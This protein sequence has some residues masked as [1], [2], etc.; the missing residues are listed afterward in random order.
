MSR[1]KARRSN[2]PIKTEP[3]SLDQVRGERR[4]VK[5]PFQIN[6]RVR[7]HISTMLADAYSIVA[8]ELRVMREA[9]ELGEE[10]DT[11]RLGQLTETLT[12]L[13]K[14]ER[15][16]EARQDPA[17]LSDDELRAMALQALELLGGGT[18]GTDSGR[19]DTTDMDP[20][21]P[22]ELPGGDQDSEID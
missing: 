16:Q 18:H 9:A 12:K 10:V 17:K 22:Y 4:I 20:G 14:E 11:K 13:A 19:S 15:E 2:L 21:R 7:P 3:L 1:P 8:E 5:A 6:A